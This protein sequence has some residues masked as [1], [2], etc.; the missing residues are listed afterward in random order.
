MPR[1][2]RNTK[3][4]NM[5]K[6]NI[7]TR[8]YQGR[9]QIKRNGKWHDAPITFRK[10][11]ANSANANMVS[12]L[13]T[14]S[15]AIALS[16]ARRRR[17]LDAAKRDPK[18][19]RLSVKQAKQLAASAKDGIMSRHYDGI[20]KHHIIRESAHVDEATGDLIV[21]MRFEYDDYEPQESKCVICKATKSKQTKRNVVLSPALKRSMAKN[22]SGKSHWP[23]KSEPKRKKEK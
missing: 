1:L 21:R 16:G 15:D 6:K 17:E 18:R 23:L 8:I 19:L 2:H 9:T 10:A 7:E 22:G 5:K 13:A 3:D 20:L 4:A 11:I 14:V 12:D